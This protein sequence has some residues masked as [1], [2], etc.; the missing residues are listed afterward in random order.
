MKFMRYLELQLCISTKDSGYLVSLREPCGESVS[1]NIPKLVDD[2]GFSSAIEQVDRVTRGSS[3][4]G[5]GH[6]KRD[7]FPVDDE[8]Q[9]IDSHR[10]VRDFGKKL[11]DFVFSG[12]VLQ[13]YRRSLQAAR[14][15]D[16][17][18]RLRLQLNAPELAALPWEFIYDES[19]GDYV[20]LLPETPI[21]RYVDLA[22]STEAITVQPP[23]RILAMTAS[24]EDLPKLDV[25][26]ERR[27]ME[28]SIEH[29]IDNGTVELEWL[30]GETCEDLHKALRDSEGENGWHIFHFIGHG[31][32]D[33]NKDEGF[34][35]LSN[36]QSKCD[37]L[38]ATRLARIL[39]EHQSI[40]MTVL[41]CCE[42][43]KA[44]KT[45]LF[46]SAGAVLTR[47]DIPAVVSMQYAITDDA[48]IKLS[49]SLYDHIADGRPVE[50]SLQKA[51]VEISLASDET[52]EWGTPVL[53]MRSPDGR[54]FQIDLC[55]AVFRDV[56]APIQSAMPSPNMPIASRS[57]DLEILL[58]RMKQRVDERHRDAFQFDSHVITLKMEPL[59][60]SSRQ[61]NFTDSNED[62]DDS[63]LTTKSLTKFFESYGGSI[64]MLGD[65][66]SG[67][68]TAM[69]SLANDLIDLAI[70][71]SQRAVPVIVHL[72]SWGG[73][74]LQDWFVEQLRVDFTFPTKV[75]RQAMTDN[76]LLFLLDGL[77][78]VSES[79]RAA[80]VDAINEFAPEV[81]LA[82]IAVTCR[83]R[84]YLELPNR[85]SLT[86]AVKI[87]PL[88][89]EDV[90]TEI[91]SW[92]E[93]YAGLLQLMARDSSLQ[94]LG[95]SP[96]ML[97]L[98]SEVYRGI[99]ADSLD[100]ESSQAIGAADR[101]E[102]LMRR[103][104]EKMFS[105]V[106]RAKQ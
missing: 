45:N 79:Q 41:N 4:K 72:S 69:L 15:E 95:K 70:K 1:L 93:S 80:C 31:G 84:E 3:H 63:D 62:S 99:P 29:L 96:L 56:D 7:L 102:E 35:A 55:S 20:S 57:R 48:A 91:Q 98:M 13:T 97:G 60:E 40:R 83:T 12:E 94:I 90:V 71:D 58:S 47:R 73:E 81:G 89:R 38:S 68:S 82:G 52:I 16:K 10:A 87:R 61:K 100:D 76:R 28:E 65:P 74:P 32:F 51:R 101:R 46:S 78:E 21:V 27:Q 36:Q 104:V 11:F 17:G 64:L 53:H 92:G 75:I 37:P 18:L 66:G 34:I 23:L 50:E 42:G 26:R 43:A 22:R 85:L 49:R 88:D 106:A 30:D 33:E 67:K 19:E 6:K 8:D 105:K 44:S 77:D 54:L 14:D 59:R 2:D 9:I 25:D 86:E 103:Y 24:P 5:S 39:A